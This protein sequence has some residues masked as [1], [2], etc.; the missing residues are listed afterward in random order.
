MD[1]TTRRSIMN[2]T[3]KAIVLASAVAVLAGCAVVPAGPPYYQPAPVYYGGP[4]YY[5]PPA[6]YGTSV[7]IGVYGGWRGGERWH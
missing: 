5:V 6:Y 3:I 4:A 1:I 2:Q 7:G